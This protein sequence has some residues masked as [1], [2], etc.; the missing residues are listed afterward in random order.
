MATITGYDLPA[1]HVL[2]VTA[3]TAAQ[4][5]QV[6]DPSI[7]AIIAAGGSHAF[8]PYGLPRKFRATGQVT[9]VITESDFSVNVPSA[10]QKA[11]LDNIPT[12]DPADDGVSVWNDEGALKTSGASV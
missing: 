4:V 12:V 10:A 2:T 3:V 8:G 5:R 9:A 6:E 7:A 11:L 1:G